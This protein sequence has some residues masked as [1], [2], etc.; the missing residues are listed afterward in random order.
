MGSSF[1]NLK[2]SERSLSAQNRNRRPIPQYQDAMQAFVARNEYYKAVD[3]YN[4]TRHRYAYKNKRE[5]FLKIGEEPRPQ[6]NMTAQQRAESA[7]PANLIGRRTV[8]TAKKINRPRMKRN[9]AVDLPKQSEQTVSFDTKKEPNRANAKS[10]L[11]KA[12]TQSR[13]MEMKA[14][15]DK[16]QQIQNQIQHLPETTKKHYFDRYLRVGE[17]AR[18]DLVVNCNEPL[19]KK[20]KVKPDNL[21]KLDS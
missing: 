20:P 1:Y 9:F 19:K 8:S 2:K 7:L 4:E 16:V 10:N 12:V 13:K 21:T 15:L 3:V 18:L 17:T 11:L 5:D 6:S 14:V